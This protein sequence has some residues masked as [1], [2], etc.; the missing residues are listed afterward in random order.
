MLETIRVFLPGTLRRIAECWPDAISSK[1][2]EI[3]IREGRPLE[4]GFDGSF[5]YV[6]EKGQITVRPQD[7]YHP[8]REDCAK[9][10]D[11]LSNHSVYTIEEELRRGYITVQGG[12]RI[13]LTGR[14]LL[15]NGQ[16]KQIRDI[17]GFN[18][19]LAREIIGAG[20]QVLPRLLDIRRKTLYHSL[21]ISPP[22]HGKTTIIRDLVRMISSGEWPAAVNW[23]AK[24]VAIVDERSELAG[25]VDGVP[26]FQV[27]PRTDVLDRA[28]K[29][30]GMMMMIRSM[31]PEVLV[32]DELGGA[33]DIAALQEAVRSGVQVLAT[34][35]GNDLDDV[36]QRPIFQAIF[37]QNVFQRIVVLKRTDQG[38]RIPA[39]YDSSGK[40]MY[41]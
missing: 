22:Q 3:R 8:G 38:L 18:I 5:A 19:R 28:P 32:V 16:V 40:I 4:I 20:A 34:A 1:L 23:Q 6:T 14:A 25:C 13:G 31:S 11:L 37:A 7:A 27:G 39:V 41:S 2:E 15:E 21:I 12:H 24:K 30:E 29:A 10:L 9:L 17:S 33:E 36:R 35:H 26:S